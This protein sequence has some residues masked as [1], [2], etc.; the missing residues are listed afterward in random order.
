MLAL[1]RAFSGLFSLDDCKWFSVG[2][3]Q[4]IVSIAYTCVI[5]HPRYLYLHSC[6]AWGYGSICSKNV[7]TCLF[8]HKVNEHLTGL[9]FGYGVIELC[10]CRMLNRLD[11]HACNELFSRFLN[12][13][14][15]LDEHRVLRDKILVERGKCFKNPEFE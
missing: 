12:L 15:S 2:S 9:G 11:C 6:L 13:G 4:N 1:I 10:L 14:N 8:Q 7:P 5:R 3:E